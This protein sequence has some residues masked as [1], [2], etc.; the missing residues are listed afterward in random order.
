MKNKQITC[1]LQ[2]FVFPHPCSAAPKCFAVSG[3]SSSSRSQKFR[4]KRE[5]RLLRNVRVE[6]VTKQFLK[7]WDSGEPQ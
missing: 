7:L 5:R 1:R 2:Y 3:I 4:N 6:K